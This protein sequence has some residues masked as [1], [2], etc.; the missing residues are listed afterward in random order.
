MD[1]IVNRLSHSELSLA[2]LQQVLCRLTHPPTVTFESSLL[3][4]SKTSVSF[5][6]SCIQHIWSERPLSMPPPSNTNGTQHLDPLSKQFIKKKK[7]EKDVFTPSLRFPHRF[8]LE[9]FVAHKQAVKLLK[10][11]CV[12]LNATEKWLATSCR[13]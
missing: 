6:M 12:V 10:S 3:I 4:F 1:K 2:C 13:I 7:K 9:N 11:E 5:Q 8:S